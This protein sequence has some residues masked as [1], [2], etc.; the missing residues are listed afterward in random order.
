MLEEFNMV[1]MA[2]HDPLV[3]LYNWIVTMIPA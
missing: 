2:I 3:A 1:F